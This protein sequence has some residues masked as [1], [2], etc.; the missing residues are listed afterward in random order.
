MELTEDDEEAQKLLKQAEKVEEAALWL[1]AG[2]NERQDKMKEAV[3]LYSRV[4][5]LSG[6]VAKSHG[7]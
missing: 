6:R 5:K 3:S 4:C 2:S 1:P 7:L